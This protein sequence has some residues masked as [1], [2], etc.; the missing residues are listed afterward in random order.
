MSDS[1]WNCGASFRAFNSS[2][3]CNE[4]EKL[5]WLKLKENRDA[6]TAARQENEPITMRQIT[7]TVLNFEQ[8]KLE[9]LKALITGVTVIPD[10]SGMM[11]NR[12]QY[13]VIVGAD[14]WQ[15]IKLH[16]VINDKIK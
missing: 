14:L 6:A 3:Y 13:A 12:N 8:Q 4:C 7:E 11:V 9:S 10:L 2:V 16:G 15:K 1:C 5:P